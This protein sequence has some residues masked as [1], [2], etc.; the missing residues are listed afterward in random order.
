MCQSASGISP[1]N[2]V[3]FFYVPVGVLYIANNVV[4][5]VPA[6]VQYIA[7]NVDQNVAFSNQKSNIHLPLKLTAIVES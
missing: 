5:Y 7:N 3:V 4:F 1:C 6:G 2:N